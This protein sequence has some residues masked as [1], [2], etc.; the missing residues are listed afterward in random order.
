MNP[1]EI[2]EL[3][4]Q[5]WVASMWGTATWNTVQQGDCKPPL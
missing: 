1:F 5:L 4:A 3:L 2:D